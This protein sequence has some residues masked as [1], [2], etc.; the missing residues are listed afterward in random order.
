MSN[1]ETSPAI[2][3]GTYEKYNNGSIFGKWL[4]LNDYDNTAEFYNACKELH[5]DEEDP[6]L[7][8]QDYE[9]FPRSLY[10]ECGG[11][12][13]IYEYLNFIH[14]HNIDADAFEAYVEL[15]NDLSFCIQNFEEAYQGAWGSDR[16]FCE[17]LFDEINFVPD[18]LANYIDYEKVTYD[19]MIGYS[20]SNGYYF[21]TDI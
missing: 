12:D 21:N 2:Y 10:F 3:V 17:Q 16:E 4:K 13:E 18:H 6:E 7:M 15:G 8:F 1:S 9:G 11:I 5:K 20:E 14:D 19:Y